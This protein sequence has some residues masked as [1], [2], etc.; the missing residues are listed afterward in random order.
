MSEYK[1]LVL[2]SG[3]R[4]IDMMTT[5]TRLGM[6]IH[7]TMRNSNWKMTAHNSRNGL[8]KTIDAGL[9]DTP[10]QIETM[11]TAMV[12]VCRQYGVEWLDDVT[13]AI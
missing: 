8:S 10:D 6:S 9:R 12:N 5:T 3:Q 11:I 2:K 7:M 4:D 1:P 13:M